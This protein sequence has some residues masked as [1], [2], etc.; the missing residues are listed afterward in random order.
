MSY[1]TRKNAVKRKRITVLD[2]FIISICLCGAAVSFYLF[3]IDFSVT[4]LFVKNKPAG[5]TQNFSFQAEWKDKPEA[6]SLNIPELNSV[7]IVGKEMADFYFSWKGF[8]EAEFYTIQIS[9]ESDIDKPVMERTTRNNYFIYGKNETAL[10]PGQYFWKVCYTDVNGQVSPLSQPW[11]FVVMEKEHNQR[12]I[13][14]P[15]RYS[16]DGEFLSDLRFS[17]ETS[18]QHDRH[19]QVSAQP[20]FSS[21]EVDVPVTDNF[22][23]GISIPPGEWDW[24]IIAKPDAGSDAVPTPA[25]R[26]TMFLSHTREFIDAR[27]IPRLSIPD[28][29]VN[30]GY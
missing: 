23:H 21:M 3:Q 29:G 22:Y 1:T 14:P 9:H 6:P 13:F 11:A 2:F 4:R 5:F 26:L 27:P 10:S 25:R 30:Y 20:D 18:L 7:I 19:F 8:K 16:I 17:W 15:D 24:R 12:L 28:S